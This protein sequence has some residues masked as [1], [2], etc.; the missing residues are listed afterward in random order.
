M[1]ALDGV[2]R[3]EGGGGAAATEPAAEVTGFPGHEE[4]GGDRKFFAGD[5]ARY[6]WANLMRSGLGGHETL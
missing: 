1:S 5:Y 4:L 3:L 6:G 2:G